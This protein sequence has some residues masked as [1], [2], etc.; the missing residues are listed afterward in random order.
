MIR[1]YIN[2]NIPKPNPHLFSYHRS[3]LPHKVHKVAP[4]FLP[5]M[6]LLA[7]VFDTDENIQDKLELDFLKEYFGGQLQH[8]ASPGGQMLF[9]VHAGVDV[10]E[11]EQKSQRRFS[12]YC[13]L[14]IVIL[15]DF[16]SKFNDIFFFFLKFAI[17]LLPKFKRNYYFSLGSVYFRMYSGRRA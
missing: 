4:P 16:S 12:V 7:R 9:A 2:L 3:I 15:D 10:K 5:G 11:V 17:V 13:F 1:N 14:P 6:Y 8:I